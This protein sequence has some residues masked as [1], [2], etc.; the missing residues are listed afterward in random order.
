MREGALNLPSS[1]PRHACYV[2]LC[3]SGSDNVHTWSAVVATTQSRS[4]FGNVLC[5]MMYL[6]YFHAAVESTPC[7]PH[8]LH[9]RVAVGVGGG[10]CVCQFVCSLC[11]CVHRFCQSAR[12]FCQSVRSI[13]QSVRRI[14]QFVRHV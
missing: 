11:Q 1:V 9:Q 6:P 14:S 12:R 5:V 10:E 13:F 3:G 8:R 4:Y 2:V 7:L